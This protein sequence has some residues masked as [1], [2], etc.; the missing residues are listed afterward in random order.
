[1]SNLVVYDSSTGLIKEWHQVVPGCEVVVEQ[2]CLVIEAP[3]IHS[4]VLSTHYVAGGEVT[5]RPKM[6]AAILGDVLSGVPEGATITIEGSNYTAD[7]SDVILEVSLPGV[8]EITVTKWP[9]LDEE[10]TYETA[11]HG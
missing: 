6:G 2:G 9:Y 11:A 5:Q 4:N 7:G 10:L 1:M 3:G 8:Y